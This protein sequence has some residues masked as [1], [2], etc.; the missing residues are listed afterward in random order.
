MAGSKKRKAYGKGKDGYQSYNRMVLQLEDCTAVF[1]VLDQQFDIVYELDHSSG[2]DKENLDG[3]TATPSMLGWGNG[4][5]QCSMRGSEVTVNNTGTVRHGQCNNLGEIQQMN[6]RIDDL[7][8][9][10]KTPLPQAFNSNRQNNDKGLERHRNESL[11][12]NRKVEFRWE[13]AS[14]SRQ[15]H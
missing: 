12:G 15:M 8:P 11:S 6:F 1:K 2:H 5:K 9:V 3:L 7:H 10:L 13:A 14:F 4:G